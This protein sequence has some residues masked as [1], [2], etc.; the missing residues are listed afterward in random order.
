MR[1]VSAVGLEDEALV[2]HESDSMGRWGSATSTMWA[3]GGAADVV[4]MRACA[5]VVVL[6]GWLRG[7]RGEVQIRHQSLSNLRLIAAA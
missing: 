5:G 4:V 3:V 6:N 7:V 2:G 1:Q